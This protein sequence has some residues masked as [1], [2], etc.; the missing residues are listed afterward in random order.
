MLEHHLASV[1]VQCIVQPLGVGLR[2]KFYN[3]VTSNHTVNPHLDSTHILTSLM[4]WFIKT[5]VWTWSKHVISVEKK[6]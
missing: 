5:C 2:A 6:M 4:R 3:V 1:F